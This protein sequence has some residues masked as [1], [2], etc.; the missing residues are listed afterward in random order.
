M[1][2]DRGWWAGQP[3]PPSL[4]AG[5]ACDGN[6]ETPDG[7]QAKRDSKLLDADLLASSMPVSV[8][9]DGIVGVAKWATSSCLYAKIGISYAIWN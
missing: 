9:E 2:Y 1:L 5:G 7:P 3:G 8:C 6:R 4:Q